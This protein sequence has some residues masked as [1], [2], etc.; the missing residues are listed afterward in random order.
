MKCNRSRED[1]CEGE[2]FVQ[3]DLIWKYKS[4]F[5]QSSRRSTRIYLTSVAVGWINN[6][7]RE[8]GISASQRERSAMWCRTGIWVIN[9]KERFID[10]RK[11]SVFFLHDARQVDPAYSDQWTRRF[12]YY[13]LSSSHSWAQC[14]ARDWRRYECICL[15]LHTTGLTGYGSIY[16][17]IQRSFRIYARPNRVNDR[18]FFSSWSDG[19][20]MWRI[21]LVRLKPLRSSTE[22]RSGDCLG[23]KQKSIVYIIEE[24]G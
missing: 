4:L 19:G 6:R 10:G 23:A 9:T 13:W 8:I 11:I 2:S 15:S 17:P 21:V 5:I 22:F 3:F 18:F 14:D 24:G 16:A 7:W 1:E 12:D 20:Q